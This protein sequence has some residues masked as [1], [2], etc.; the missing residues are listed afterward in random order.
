MIKLFVF[1]SV[2]TIV[3]FVFSVIL[4]NSSVYDA[5]WSVA[6]MVMVVWRRVFVGV[7]PVQCGLYST[8]GKKTDSSK[9]RL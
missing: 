1:D 2:A 3:T 4:R 5:Y 7:H 9:A 8:D 6:P